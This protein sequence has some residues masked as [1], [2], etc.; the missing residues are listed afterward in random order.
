ML[1]I[2]KYS[3]W[4]DCGTNAVIQKLLSFSHTVNRYDSLHFKHKQLPTPTPQG[5]KRSSP[6]SLTQTHSHTHTHRNG[7]T[8]KLLRDLAIPYTLWSRKTLSESMNRPG[9]NHVTF[10]YNSSWSETDNSKHGE[11][12]SPA[13]IRI[14]TDFQ[15]Y[16]LIQTTGRQDYRIHYSGNNVY[17]IK[18]I[19]W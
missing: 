5:I 15:K 4:T 16:R 14:S 7:R 17:N 11:S 18:K 19:T 13:T 12:D 3:H 6:V 10:P 2:L 1:V 9:L 8:K